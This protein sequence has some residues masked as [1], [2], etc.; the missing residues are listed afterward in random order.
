VEGEEEEEEEEV[1]GDGMMGEEEVEVVGGGMTEMIPLPL[2]AEADMKGIRIGPGGVTMSGETIVAE[3][4]AMTEEGIEGEEGE[5]EGDGEGDEGM[6]R[7]TIHGVPIRTHH[8]RH[9]AV[10][11]S[12]GGRL[13]NLLILGTNLLLLPLELQKT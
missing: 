12:L 2:V 10:L 1:M 13:N 8:D 5:I 4:I 3:E 7:T 6:G 11:S 9:K